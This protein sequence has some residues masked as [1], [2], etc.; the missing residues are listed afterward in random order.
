MSFYLSALFFGL[1]FY[2]LFKRI[3]Y[4]LCSNICLSVPHPNPSKF[5]VTKDD[6]F[7]RG[8]YKPEI[9]NNIKVIVR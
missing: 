6:I 4:S 8:V 3:N 7:A 2:F 9:V 5:I 1:S